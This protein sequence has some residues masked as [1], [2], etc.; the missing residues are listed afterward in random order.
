MRPRALTGLGVC[1]ALGVGREG[2][3]RGLAGARPLLEQPPRSIQGWDATE[4]P[5]ARV[6]E[7]PD[8]DPTRW[9]GDKG[10]RTLDRLTKLMLVAARTAMHDAGLKK[11]NQFVATTPDRVGLCCSNAYGSLEAMVELSRVALLEDPRYINPARFPNTV[12]NSASGYVSI[13]E[14]LR[15][16]NVAVSNGNCGALDALAMADVYL[17]AGRADAV[18]AGGGEASSEALFLA[19]DKL[20][21]LESGAVLGEAAAFFVVETAEGARARGAAPLAFALGAGTAFE[22]PESEVQMIHASAEALERAIA[23]ALEDAGVARDAI[24][25]V[26]SGVSGLKAFD[27][28]ELAGIARAVRGDVAAVAPKAVL[29]ETFGA[30]G[31]LAVATALAYLGGGAP[32][33]ELVAGTA[34]APIRTA[35]VTSLGY[36]GNASAVVL[37]AP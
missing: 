35:L 26:V 37:R 4:H 27:R 24:D 15:A 36:Y 18:L 19:F 28:A 34:R 17:D 21:A 30:G 11:D 8:F 3:A 1:S 23:L 33:L 14:D 10:L 16:L 32:S 31:A 20:G 25:L 22:P 29:G 6:A 9:L 12:A 13:W 2:F 5:G 7:V